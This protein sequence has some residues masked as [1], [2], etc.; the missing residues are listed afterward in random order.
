MPHYAIN[1]HKYIYRLHWFFFCF[2][3]FDFLHTWHCLWTVKWRKIKRKLCNSIRNF[4]KYY[5][6]YCFKQQ[7]HKGSFVVLCLPFQL[8]WRCKGYSKGFSFT[9][10]I[11]T[12]AL[13]KHVMDHIYDIYDTCFCLLNSLLIQ[14]HPRQH[15]F[16]AEIRRIK[17]EQKIFQG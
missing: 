9:H 16:Y 14:Q 15:Y 5:V 4:P 6:V 8:S 12:Q 10:L 1:K 2:L 13:H 17:R 3:P 7:Q 11:F